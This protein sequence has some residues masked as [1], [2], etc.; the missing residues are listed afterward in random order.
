MGIVQAAAAA[1][2]MLV[3]GCGGRTMLAGDSGDGTAADPGDDGSAPD[4][5]PDTDS[6]ESEAS[7]DA[8]DG[9]DAEDAEAD[10]ARNG[11]VEVPLRTPPS[12]MFW[13][14]AYDAARRRIVLFGGIHIGGG[15]IGYRF[16]DTWEYDGTD[17]VRV[18]TATA[19]APAPTT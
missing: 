9:G 14:A 16:D 18:R 1:I 19:P 13:Q 6:S 2:L 10:G 5:L 12:G 8:G 3:L 11:W 7:P 15:T 17:W 4:E